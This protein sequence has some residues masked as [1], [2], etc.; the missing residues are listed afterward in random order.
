MGEAA[1]KCVTAS[2]LPDPPC[3]KE[4][5]ERKACVAVRLKPPAL[6]GHGVWLASCHL[7]FER[8][9]V[10]INGAEQ[11]ATFVAKVQT[12]RGDEPFVL[13]GDFNADL[14]PQAIEKFRH[15]GDLTPTKEAAGICA[16][17]SEVGLRLAAPA[18]T[19][20]V[21]PDTFFEMKK[22]GACYDYI[23]VGGG[24]I[25]T[26]AAQRIQ[27]QP[28]PVDDGANIDVERFPSDHDAV[29]VQVRL[30]SAPAI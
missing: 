12:A 25:K 8:Y 1:D 21:C 9:G 23:F 30:K 19:L 17:L 7:G 24:H 20:A 2:V 5:P 13:A 29:T 27:A 16:A 10:N 3:E 15:F 14:R 22:F 18:A 28:F 11:L 6:S 4:V 26:E